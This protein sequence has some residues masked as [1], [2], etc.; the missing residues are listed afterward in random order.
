M[1]TQ[2]NVQSRI[3]LR[4]LAEK[5]RSSL[6]AKESPDEEFLEEI[7]GLIRVHALYVELISV[8]VALERVDAI[9]TYIQALDKLVSGLNTD[10]YSL[11]PEQV[12][13]TLRVINGAVQ[14]TYQIIRDMTSGRDA[15]T[16][17]LTQ[18]DQLV[19]TANGE[20]STS[21]LQDKLKAMSPEQ[22]ARV[23]AAA[24]HVAS[25]YAAG[26]GSEG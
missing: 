22:R 13:N 9:P 17:L 14:D 8:M 24:Q 1:A 21:A 23:V 11:T 16:V 5:L 6:L 12:V 18:L 4:A 2:D 20:V 7:R 26:V 25:A 15:T 19:Q 10:M 3:K